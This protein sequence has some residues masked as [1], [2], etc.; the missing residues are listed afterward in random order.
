MS[1][2]ANVPEYTPRLAGVE[3][4]ADRLRDVSIV[5]RVSVIRKATADAADEAV[6]AVEVEI[7]GPG[8]GEDRKAAAVSIV[9]DF[10]QKLEAKFDVIATPYEKIAFFMLDLLVGHIVERAYR[11]AGLADV[12]EGG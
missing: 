5:E 6:R 7:P 4:L 10:L 2:P 8:H 12:D 3:S 9:R 11:E 1:E